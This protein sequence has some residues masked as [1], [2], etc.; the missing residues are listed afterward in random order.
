VSREVPRRVMR[1]GST[2]NGVVAVEGGRATG[3]RAGRVLRR[4]GR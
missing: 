4:P 1:A 2:V 3:A